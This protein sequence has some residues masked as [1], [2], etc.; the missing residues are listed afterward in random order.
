VDGN[1]YRLKTQKLKG[2]AAVSK[3]PPDRQPKPTGKLWRT[4][5]PPHF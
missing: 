3:S 4:E 1:P 2:Q 5:L